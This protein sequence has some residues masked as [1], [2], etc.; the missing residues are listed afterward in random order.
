MPYRTP[1]HDNV[2]S[3]SGRFHGRFSLA[4]YGSGAPTHLFYDGFGPSVCFPKPLN[5]RK[6]WLTE[7]LDHPK[8]SMVIQQRTFL[9]LATVGW[10]SCLRLLHMIMFG[11]VLDILRVLF[12][13]HLWGWGSLTKP[14][15]RRGPRKNAMTQNPKSLGNQSCHSNVLV[16][17]FVY[18]SLIAR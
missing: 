2:W 16:A 7:F 8:P 11:V 1:T 14:L 17:L 12:S 3:R 9:L 5:K 4:I 15:W 6:R 10:G 13:R 18:V